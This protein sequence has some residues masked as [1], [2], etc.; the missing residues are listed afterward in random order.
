MVPPRAEPRPLLVRAGRVHKGDEHSAS[1]VGHSFGAIHESGPMRA[2][3]CA[4]LSPQNE[5]KRNETQS[6]L[7]SRRA[8]LKTR[9]TDRWLATLSALNQRW[10][11]H[12]LL[13][14]RAH[15]FRQA[16]CQTIEPLDSCGSIGCAAQWRTILRPLKR[17]AGATT[18]KVARLHKK[19]WAN[20]F[21]E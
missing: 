5:T 4:D 8:E 14:S 11:A 18:W 16:A 17:L 7:N 10:R 13:I 6:Q 9:Q 21:S 12:T 1:S 2:W 20:F 19:F 15:S 3:G